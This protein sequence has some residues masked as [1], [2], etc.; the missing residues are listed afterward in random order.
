MWE[1]PWH[2]AEGWA[3]VAAARDSRTIG[4]VA[5]EPGRTADIDRAFARAH[6]EQ[7]AGLFGGPKVDREFDRATV[8]NWR[9]L[10][11]AL[12][13]AAASL[14]VALEWHLW[15]GLVV[16]VAGLVAVRWVLPRPGRHRATRRM[17]K[18][19]KP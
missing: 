18:G 9:V 6:A 7:R 3:T 15:A 14:G 19:W 8:A 4:M 2:I 1:N 11:W 5:D 16:F 13:T 12:W 10:S 17:P